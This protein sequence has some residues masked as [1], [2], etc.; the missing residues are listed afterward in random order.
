[1]LFSFFPCSSF[2]LF[3]GFKHAPTRPR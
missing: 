3:F 1:V 2:F